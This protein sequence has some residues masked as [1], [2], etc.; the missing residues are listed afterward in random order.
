[1]MGRREEKMIQVENARKMIN[2]RRRKQEEKRG[3][4]TC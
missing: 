2:R 3:R 4:G 1:M